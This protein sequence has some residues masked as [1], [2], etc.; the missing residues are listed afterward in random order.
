M[1]YV[2]GQVL[3]SG[4]APQSPGLAG[5]NLSGKQGLA[6]KWHATNK[7]VIL[8]TAGVLNGILAVRGIFPNYTDATVPD[9]QELVLYLQGAIVCAI[10]GGVVAM[11]APLTSDGDGK[12][13]TA[14]T[15]ADMV[16]GYAWQEGA[17]AEDGV[18][19]VIITGPWQ[20][21]VPA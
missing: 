2:A 11:N 4:S 12:L 16:I 8:G 5:A 10:A 20:L 13:L 9:S 1:A 7:R 19:P 6:W 17:A 18:F 3:N 14:S 15:D 21:V